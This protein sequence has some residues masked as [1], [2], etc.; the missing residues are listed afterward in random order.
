VHF[1]G[2][3]VKRSTYAP[4]VRQTRH[5]HEHS[6]VTVVTGGQ[7][8]EGTEHGEYCARPFSVV[9][10][11]AGCEHDDRI[12]GRGAQTLTIQFA[13]ASSFGNLVGDAS[14]RW[15]EQPDIVRRALVLHRAFSSSAASETQRAA[16]DLVESIVA[17]SQ[18]AP[19]VPSWLRELRALLDARFDETLRFEQ[20]ARDHGVHPVYASRAFQR[21]VGVSMTDYVRGLRIRSA[22]HS[23]SASCRSIAAIAAESGFVDAS[24]LCRTFSSLLGTTPRAYRRA[25]SGK[26]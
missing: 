12:G 8:E 11:A 3:V 10:K 14:W 5:A 15:F 13:R 6:N 2:F 20:L 19:A 21:Y 17:S 22:R 16:V 7:I 1:D 25:A 23:L 18:P 24:H 4:G 26:V 9:V